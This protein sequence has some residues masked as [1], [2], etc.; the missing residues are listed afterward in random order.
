MLGLLIATIASFSAPSVSPAPPMGWNSYDCFSYAVTER[1]V[2]ANARFMAAHL[3]Q[4]GWNYV[5]VDYA[6]YMPKKE[7]GFAYNQ[8]D[9]FEPSMSLDKWGRPQPDPL[10]FPSAADGDGFKKLASEIHRMG[11]KFGIHLMRGIPAQAVS[12]NDPIEG[13][14][15]HAGDAASSDNRCSWLNLMDSLNMSQP[16]SQAY[17]NSLFRQ[18]ASWGVDFVKVDDM[19]NPYHTATIA[20]YRRAI[21]QCGRKII[22]SL[23]P[24]ETPVSEAEDVSTKANMWRLLGDMWD[25]WPQLH[26][27]FS[28]ARRWVS[29][30]SPGHW[31]DLDMLPLGMLREYGPNTGP[32][33]TNCRLTTVEQRTLMTLWCITKSPLMFGGDLTKSSDA[34]I[35]LITNPEVLKADQTEGT[36]VEV[37]GG[38]Y[39]VWTAPAAGNVGQYFAAFNLTNKPYQAT[40]QFTSDGSPVLVR[41]VWQRR[42]LGVAVGH[43]SIQLPAHGS[44]MAFLSRTKK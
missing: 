4:Y 18:Y 41:D 23:S 44:F 16:A 39:P 34:T 6:W 26:H 29:Y 43:F 10:R 40:I 35:R 32:W 5:V 19:T 1:Q 31:P 38:D 36:P 20:G 11:L 27:A 14:G 12:Q 8:N 2:L 21:Q 9:S 15:Y 13:S 28:V 33:N 22:L 30:R 42:N 25:T 7:A 3:K 37:R 17:L 24:G